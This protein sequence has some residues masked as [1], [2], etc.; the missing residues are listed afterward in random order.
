[1]CTCWD[2]VSLLKSI[3]LDPS[4]NKCLEF[5]DSFKREIKQPAITQIHM[6]LTNDLIDS[7]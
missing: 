2:F 6:V 3:T 7:M 5:G 4:C 1:M